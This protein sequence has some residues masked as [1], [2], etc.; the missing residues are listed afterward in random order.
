MGLQVDIV[1]VTAYLQNCSLLWDSETKKGAV[2]DPGGD[3]AAILERIDKH[4]IEVEKI[5][6]THGHFDHIGGVSALAQALQERYGRAIP[7]LGSQKEDK[8]LFD[9]LDEQ[10]ASFGFPSAQPFTPDRWLEEGDEVT[11]GNE[12]LSVYHTPGHTPGHITYYGKGIKL[13]WVGDVL[14]KDSIGRT[15]LAGGDYPTLINSIRN[16]LWSLDSQTTFVP[17]HGPFSTFAEERRSN[18]Y[19]SDKKLN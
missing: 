13:A 5:L 15:D 18:P 11:V 7:I 19:V 12:V 16:K 8:F 3:V 2:I 10:L 17:G 4:S 9:S 1:Q 6:I 14:F